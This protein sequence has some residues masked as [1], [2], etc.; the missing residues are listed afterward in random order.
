MC[1]GYSVA[2]EYRKLM[3]LG[4]MWVEDWFRERRLRSDRTAGGSGAGERDSQRRAEGAVG[5]G[6]RCRARGAHQPH[7]IAAVLL[8]VLA[9]LPGVASAG[10]T[11]MYKLQ[12]IRSFPAVED[13]QQH[14][15]K[16]VLSETYQIVK[17]N[18]QDLEFRPGYDAG[19]RAGSPQVTSSTFVG[20]FT[21]YD[22]FSG[23]FHGM[24]LSNC[25][26]QFLDS[27]SLLHCPV[28]KEQGRNAGRCVITLECGRGP[29]LD[30][31][32][33]RAT[34]KTPFEVAV[35]DFFIWLW[36]RMF[37][38][39]VVTTAAFAALGLS[40]FTVN[41]A[42]QRSRAKK[43]YTK[44]SLLDWLIVPDSF[45]G[46]EEP[47]PSPFRRARSADYLNLSLSGDTGADY[48]DDPLLEKFKKKPNSM[49]HKRNKSQNT[50]GV[51]SSHPSDQNL[52][53]RD[54]SHSSNS[55]SG[56]TMKKI[57][58]VPAFSEYV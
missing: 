25:S 42:F 32:G 49:A 17:R 35:V 40:F 53:R 31:G 46:G 13:L 27:M 55:S 3:F 43:G 39:M 1:V 29:C 12:G 21:G 37:L 4:G 11:G 52:H 20:H 54:V 10:F 26:G 28:P 47:P 6:P 41:F 16:I 8:F 5:Q 44:V 23:N 38:A 9:T 2:K 7:L 58:S 34:E 18:E 24:L 14:C 15:N 50:F 22:T 57:V 51:F 45:Q 19:V 48:L 33:S 56:D 30:K 36:K